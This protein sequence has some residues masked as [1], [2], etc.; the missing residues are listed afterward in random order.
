M[1][2][3]ISS[4][5]SFRVSIG[6]MVNGWDPGRTRMSLNALKQKRCGSSFCLW[7]GDF[8]WHL[9]SCQFLPFLIHS[10]FTALDMSYKEL[11]LGTPT[12]TMTLDVIPCCWTLVF[13]LYYVFD[14]FLTCPRLSASFKECY[15]FIMSSI[16]HSWDPSCRHTIPVRF[17]HANAI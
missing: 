13:L 2:R 10:R 11:G 3:W 17:Y 12:L 8:R 6:L 7:P 16:A 14:L 5:G 1:E 4:W 15:L 9:W